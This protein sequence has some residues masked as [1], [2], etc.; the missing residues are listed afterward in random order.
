MTKEG[1][2][3]SKSPS[4][5]CNPEPLSYWYINNDDSLRFMC[6]YPKPN[7]WYRFWNWALVG[8][9]WEDVR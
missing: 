9:R 6:K 1:I 8:V 4:P 2:T 5:V 3:Y 7:A